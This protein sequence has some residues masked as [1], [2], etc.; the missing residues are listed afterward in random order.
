MTMEPRFGLIGFEV[1][2]Q[3]GHARVA[4]M[5]LAHGVVETPVFMPVGTQGT[6]KGLSPEEVEGTGAQLLL[7]NTYHLYLRPGLEV[8]GAHGGLHGMM[9]WSKPILT[10]SGGY[11]VFSLKEFRKISEQGVKFRDHVQ[12]DQHML[13]PELAVKIQETIGSDIMMVLDECPELPAEPRYMAASL[14]RTTRWARRCLEARTRPDCALFAINQG[15]VDVALRRRHAQ[16]LEELPFDGFAL[17]GLSVGE[18]K[19]LMYDTVEGVAPHMKADRPRYLMGVGTP[20]D[21]LECVSRGVDMFDCVMPTRNGRNGQMFTSRGKV[22][23]KHQRWRVDLGPPDPACDCYTCQKY[24]LSYLRHLYQ[25]GEMLAGRLLTIHNLRYYQRLMEGARGAIREGR[26][27][28]YV[29]GCKAGWE[30]LSGRGGVEQ[31]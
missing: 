13:T 18:A 5:E 6:V 17:G 21:L 1:L 11:Q 10:D 20:Q 2:A 22:V 24:S 9:G 25:S 12:G 26:L 23:I 14:A 31:G 3:D 28:A 30:E 16:E 29:A 27:G 19:P 7:G 8:I 15:G 4:R